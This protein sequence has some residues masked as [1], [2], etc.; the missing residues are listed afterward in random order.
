MHRLCSRYLL[1]YG[2]VGIDCRSINGW[3]VSG[4]APF[5]CGLTTSLIIVPG[6]GR[7]L[8][9]DLTA[10]LACSNCRGQESKKFRTMGWSG[11]SAKGRHQV[12]IRV[13][14][15]KKGGHVDVPYGPIDRLN[16]DRLS[17]R[18]SFNPVEHRRLHP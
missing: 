11:W 3:E 13:N 7:W 8:L 17:I 10:P 16:P 1:V 14:R 18:A 6:A 2:L 9:A 4:Y 12:D 15:R 5:S